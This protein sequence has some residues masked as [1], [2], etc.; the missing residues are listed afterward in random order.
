MNR[1]S[2][3]RWILLGGGILLALL[4][5][6]VLLVVAPRL[7]YR[8]VGLAG[9]VLM[10]LS[11]AVMVL[12][13]R[14]AKRVNAMSQVVPVVVSLV[15]V[16]IYAA[17]L[18]MPVGVVGA[19]GCAILGILVGAGWGLAGRFVESRGQVRM[20]GTPWHLVVWGCVFVLNQC[21]AMIGGRGPAAMLL[22]LFLSVGLVFGRSGVTL[23]RYARFRSGMRVAPPLL[24]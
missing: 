15:T 22:L 18:R 16:A 3:S 4:L 6:A 12:T 24:S 17:V 1:H 23:A 21:V 5:S 20:T 11:V 7:F 14:R 8:F 2:M 10:V 13:C 19:V 9:M